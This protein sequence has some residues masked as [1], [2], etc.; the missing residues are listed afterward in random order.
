MADSKVFSGVRGLLKIDGV[1]VGWLAGAS[2]STNLQQTPLEVCNNVDVEEYVTTGRN[3]S[4]SMETVRLVDR[5]LVSI[6][7]LPGGGASSAAVASFTG[8]TAQIC[9]TVTDK[10]LVQMEGLKLTSYNWSM[11]ARGIVMDNAAWVA[12]KCKLGSELG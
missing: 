3:H 7:L 9:D 12:P 8:K 2:G 6:G 1:T 11:A 4:G 10:V 5:D